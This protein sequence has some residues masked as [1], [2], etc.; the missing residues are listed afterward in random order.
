[1]SSFMSFGDVPVIVAGSGREV[2]DEVAMNY[3]ES[4][5]LIKSHY[6]AP[7][8]QHWALLEIEDNATTAIVHFVRV[9]DQLRSCSAIFS[10]GTMQLADNC[11]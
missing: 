8:T 10:S 6:L 11:K 2:R 1:M 9:K 7:R 4:G 3:S 5:V